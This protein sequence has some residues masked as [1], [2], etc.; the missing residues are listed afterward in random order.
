MRFVRLTVKDGRFN[1][2]RD[3]YESRVIPALQNT[4]GCLF[5][6]LLQP[7]E[8]ENECVSLTLWSSQKRV[9]EYE[10]S[11]LYDELLDES[12]DFLAEASEWRV[13][14]AGDH[15]GDGPRLQEP[16]VEASGH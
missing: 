2:L 10:N 7:T 12:D 6:S 3:F 9:E 11:G 8:G 16:E 15:G 14:L 4:R 13:Q 5:V 1:D